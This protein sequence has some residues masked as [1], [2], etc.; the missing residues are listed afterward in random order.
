[1]ITGRDGQVRGAVLKVASKNG[2]PSVLQRP[3]QLLYPLEVDGKPMIDTLPETEQSTLNTPDDD[4]DASVAPTQSNADAV[5]PRPRRAAA[6][7][8][9]GRV[10]EWCANLS[11]DNN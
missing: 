11:D 5:T 9:R 7:R 4:C 1:M 8:A 2:Q 10:R 3:L 6:V